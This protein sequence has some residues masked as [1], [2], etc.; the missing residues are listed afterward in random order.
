MLGR[1]LCWQK[2]PPISVPIGSCLQRLCLC[3]PSLESCLLLGLLCSKA[4]ETNCPVLSL[5][6]VHACSRAVCSILCTPNLR[7]APSVS[8]ETASTVAVNLRQKSNP[9]QLT[10]HLARA[11]APLARLVVRVSIAGSVPAVGAP[12]PHS[13]GRTVTECPEPGAQ[14]AESHTIGQHTAAGTPCPAVTQILRRGQD[15]ARSLESGPLA[16]TR[17]PAS[18][19]GPV[20]Q[21]TRMTRMTWIHRQPSPPRIQ[22]STCQDNHQNDPDT[23]PTMN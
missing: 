13:P 6:H 15:C 3:V 16:R 20:A 8:S 12:C 4:E 23:Y 14:T 7:I 5:Q 21:W 18:Q 2:L 19:H 22:P 9:R 1:V 11:T 10:A 17:R